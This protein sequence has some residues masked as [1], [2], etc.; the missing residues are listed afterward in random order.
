MAPIII[1]PDLTI[2]EEEFTYTASRASGPGGQHVNTTSS[3]ITVRF[4]AAASPSLNEWQ[5][6]KILEKLAGYADKEGVVAVSCETQRSQHANRREALA[7]LISLL[8]R[9]LKPR[10]PRKPTRPTLASKVRRVD[11]KKRRSGIKRTRGKVGDND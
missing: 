5:R 9:A 8:Q 2:P 10:I 11:S 6:A 7:R 3:R 1:L 4:N